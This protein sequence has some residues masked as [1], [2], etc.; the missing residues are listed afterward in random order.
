VLT[1]H[2]LLFIFQV[3]IIHAQADVTQS[4]NDIAQGTTGQI[5]GPGNPAN[6][7]Q[8]VLT[9][10]GGV[11]RSVIVLVGIVFLILLIAAG[12]MWLTSAGSENQI[13]KAKSI[14]ST[15]V[16]GIVIIALAYVIVTFVMG[17]F[18]GTGGAGPSP[19]CSRAGL[20]CPNGISDC[21]D[22]V[23]C[24]CINNICV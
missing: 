8:G 6:P 19:S 20:P 15:S 1:L 24:S 3:P 22:T 13:K 23:N 5:G 7:S 16:I 21:V 12:I 11:V 4:L 10:A 14:I 2:S 18:S 9:V 17:L